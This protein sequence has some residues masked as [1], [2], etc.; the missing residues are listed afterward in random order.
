MIIW[1]I[2]LSGAGK[3]AVG[4]E[5]YRE[6]RARHPNT[7]FLDGD[8]FRAVVGDDLGHSL[9]ERRRNADR[10]CRL[11][12]LLD[13]QGINAVCAILSVFH[14]SQRWNRAHFRHYF[15]VLLEVPF[16]ELVRRD[17]KGLYRSAL[18]GETH[19]VVGVDIEFPRPCR[20][21]LVLENGGERSVREVA[22][23]ILDQLPKEPSF[24]GVPV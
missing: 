5:V 1:L 3:T 7:V 19:D 6:L 11:C 10:F 14:D 17:R 18:A 2:G 22:R 8:A 4:R 9:E 15:E 23:T 16:D 12:G 24:Y 21:D 20:P 13:E